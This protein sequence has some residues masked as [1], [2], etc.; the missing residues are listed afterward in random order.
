MNNKTI[1]EFL[2]DCDLTYC[3]VGNVYYAEKAFIV[4]SVINWCSERRQA[5]LLEDG[6]AAACIETVKRFIQNELDIYWKDDTIVIS[7]KKNDD[8]AKKI[9]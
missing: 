7:E 9:R 1:L 5:G 8:Q 4:K 6:Q 3:K 2:A